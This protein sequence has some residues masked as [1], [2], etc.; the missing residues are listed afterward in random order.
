LTTTPV[1]EL[2]PGHSSDTR[3]VEQRAPDAGTERV[4]A[5]FID[6]ARNDRGVV[7]AM[8]RE[9]DVRR[10]PFGKVRSD[11]VLQITAG[12]GMRGTPGRLL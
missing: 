3:P 1:V 11:R 12:H 10:I 5:K 4:T 9:L 6:R 2:Q 8:N 7:A